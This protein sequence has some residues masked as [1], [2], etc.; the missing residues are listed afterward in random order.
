ML[1]VKDL[2]LLLDTPTSPLKTYIAVF[3]H[4]VARWERTVFCF[5][6][7][8]LT[9]KGLLLSF[10]IPFC[11]LEVH[12]GL[13]A[14]CVAR[15]RPAAVVVVVLLAPVLPVEGLL[16]LVVLLLLILPP[17]LPVEGILLLF[18]CYCWFYPLCRIKAYWCCCC[19][20]C[21]CCFVSHCV[22]R[23]SPLAPCSPGD[24]CSQSAGSYRSGL[25]SLCV[26]LI[27]YKITLLSPIWFLELPDYQLAG[28]ENGIRRPHFCLLSWNDVSM[29]GH[30]L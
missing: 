3:W 8:V 17:V 18:R 27:C 2:L 23:W 11:P 30:V 6:N 7:P 4:P 15:W 14:L 12:R 13:L 28:H 20:C 26:P 9:V 21:S 5:C 19:C 24:G 29:S 25:D 16:L 10:D 22:A 1:P